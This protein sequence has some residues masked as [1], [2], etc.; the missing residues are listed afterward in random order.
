MAKL[1][2]LKQGLR[3]KGIRISWQDPKA[4]LL[5][6]AL[7]RGDRRLGKV[8]HRAWQ[9]GCVF[10]SWGEHFN[11]ENWSRAFAENGLKPE[12]YARRQRSLDEVLPWSHIDVGVTTAFLKREYQLSK[13]SKATRDCRTENCN[14]CGLE[15][16]QPACR[17]KL[18][19]KNS[20][21]KSG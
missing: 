6:A 8:V 11:Y 10:D 16:L 3:R 5:E 14:A 9:L 13:K 4:S 15:H 20:P 7:S 1:E 17:Q 19:S 18:E 21:V 12:F 2:L